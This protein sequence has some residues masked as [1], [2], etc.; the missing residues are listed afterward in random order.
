[1]KKKPVRAK[2][3]PKRPRIV[4]YLLSADRKLRRISLKRMGIR[5]K[6]STRSAG[7]ARGRRGAR[8]KSSPYS[9]WVMRHQKA[10]VISS[11]CL[12]GAAVIIASME[13]SRPSE[14]SNA[15]SRSD[16][17]PSVDVNNPIER[18]RARTPPPVE[19]GPRGDTSRAVKPQLVAATDVHPAQ[20]QAAEY[21]AAST[22]VPATPAGETTTLAASTTTPE[23]SA[24]DQ[25]PATIT[26]CLQAD[27]DSFWLKDTTGADAPTSRSW[28]SGFLR[29]RPA[30]IE[31]VGA[32][33]ALRL[34]SYIGQRVTATGTLVNHE[35]QPRVVHR[36]ATSCS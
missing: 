2:K 19:A 26:G 31:L 13:P 25:A 9:A 11:M 28:K 33:D 29:K 27:A 22:N 23:V 1:M 30:R 18:S 15:A 6:A 36:L 35:M 32:V 10:L 21:S 12:V 24:K 17:L 14:T 7:P 16:V 4:R 8:A 34:P 5:R 20:H 3:A